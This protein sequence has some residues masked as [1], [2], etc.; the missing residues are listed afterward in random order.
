MP[1][2]TT[3][4]EEARH[5]R[6]IRAQVES[7]LSHEEFCRREGVSLHAFRTWKYRRQSACPVEGRP[8]LIPVRLVSASDAAIELELVKGR[9]VRVRPG[10]DEATL[11]RLLA[12]LERASC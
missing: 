4:A 11:V 6:L 5:R 8:R 3:R 9:T 7:G 2:R 1:A 10:F 12:A